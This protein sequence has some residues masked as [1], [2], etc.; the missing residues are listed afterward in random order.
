M[1]LCMGN[2]PHMQMFEFLVV[3]PMLIIMD[4]EGK[5]LQVEVDEVS[6][7]VIPMERKVGVCMIWSLE[8]FLSQG[9][10]HF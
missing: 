6:L 2:L 9:M 8:R 7:L 1:K 10:L 3:C 5:N 4:M